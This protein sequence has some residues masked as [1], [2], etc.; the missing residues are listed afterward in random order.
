MNQFDLQGRRA[1][2]TGGASG[3]GRAVV[4][5]FLESG[6]SVVIWDLAEDLLAEARS[7]LE[8]YGHVETE[9]VNVTDVDD[10]DRA[11]AAAEEKLG[12]G[13]DILVNSAGVTCAPQA[14]DGYPIDDWKLVIDVN[15]SGLFY[16]CRAVIPGM[17]SRGYGRVVNVASMAGKEG[18]PQET[19]YSAAKAGVIGL[20]KSL[21]KEAAVKGVLVNAVAPGVFET[22]MRTSGA[23][24]DLVGQ[25]LA[26]MP[27]GRAGHEEE[28]GALVTWIASE[29]CSFTTGFCFDASGG[30]ATY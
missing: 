13:I 19:A 24:K 29:D 28:L 1:I 9:A 10:V 6:A 27:V 17:M 3:L 20:T 14:I 18:N 2:V 22:P 16:C 5:R 30:R 21:G 25:L 15:L 11:A 8:Q 7:S 4:Q 26:R 12:G 23:S